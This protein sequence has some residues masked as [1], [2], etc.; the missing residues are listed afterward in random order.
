MIQKQKLSI[1]RLI[2]CETEFLRCVFQPEIK[3]I[4]VFL[5]APHCISVLILI[6]KLLLLL[7]QLLLLFR[8]L[9]FR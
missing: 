9:L 4:Y 7:Q 8:L 2:S 1:F 3:R 5:L 6:F